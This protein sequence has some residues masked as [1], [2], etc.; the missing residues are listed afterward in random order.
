MP[1][2]QLKQDFKEQFPESGE[3]FVCCA[4]G[5]VNLMGEHLDYNGLPVLPLLLEQSVHVAF[6]PRKDNQV[7]LHNLDETYPAVHFENALDI[8]SAPQGY[9]D[10][11]ARAVVHG[12]NHNFELDAFPGMDV[13]VTSDL[14]ASAGLSSSTAL[15]VAIGLAYL[16]VI[17]RALDQDCSRIE[18]A[19]IL[20]KAEQ[21]TGTKGGGMDQT[22]ILCAQPGEAA[23]IDFFPTR[24]ESLPLPEA[25]SFVVSHCGVDAAKG[26]SQQAAYNAG[27]YCSRIICALVRKLM[28]E[29]FG[30]DLLLPHLGELWYGPLCLTYD[31]ARIYCETALP[32]EFMQLST[33]A[34][35]LELTPD[36]FSERYWSGMEVPEAGFPLRARMR[37]I[38][39]EFKRVE[40]ARDALLE[41]DI[42]LLGKLMQDSHQSCSQDYGVSCPALDNLVA[43]ALFGGALGARLT[44]AG[45]G[46]CVVSLVPAD[47]VDAF[48]AHLQDTF[49]SSE[50]YEG[51]TPLSFIVCPGEAAR[52]C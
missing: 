35:E 16:S 23:K 50:D 51:D 29:E 42:E 21:Y 43:A 33:I 37:H 5:R 30:E 15:S 10:N 31:E 9:W 18:L 20:A 36:A 2:V 3:P 44:G 13:L 39:S 28:Q 41:G 8:P 46:G 32:D 49:Y 19:E 26:A 40:L 22:I 24:L 7:N 25:Y 27:P 48:T 52:Y 45:F 17:D 12:L 47:K 14:P 4:P 11:Y 6:A 34:M 1:E 38:L